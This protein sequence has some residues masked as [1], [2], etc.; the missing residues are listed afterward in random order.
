MGL[1]SRLTFSGLFMLIGIVV[2]LV[3]WAHTGSFLLYLLAITVVVLLSRAVFR[4]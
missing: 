2:S 3:V 1:F 4:L